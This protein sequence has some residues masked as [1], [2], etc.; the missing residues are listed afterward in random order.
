MSGTSDRV[1]D[2]PTSVSRVT[3]TAKWSGKG[4]SNFIV[5][6]NWRGWLNETVQ[7]TNGTFSGTYATS[8]GVI[9]VVRSGNTSWTFT[10]VR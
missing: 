6:A 7:D 5:Q 4:T 10:Q 2:M 9:A 8:G 3:V 1:F